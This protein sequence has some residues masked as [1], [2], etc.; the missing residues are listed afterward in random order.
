[1][2]LNSNK[3]H[4]NF[5]YPNISIKLFL[6]KSTLKQKGRA[7]KLQWGRRNWHGQ[8]LEQEE[9]V[10]GLSSSNSFLSKIPPCCAPLQQTPSGRQK[11]A[12]LNYCVKTT[13]KENK[14][15]SERPIRTLRVHSSGMKRCAKT[16]PSPIKSSP[17]TLLGF[18]MPIP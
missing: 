7:Q 17:V 4:N 2:D 3:T 10:L 6:S 11:D 1:M 8:Y 13:L 12:G 15:H 5:H 9:T 14:K 18:G 16:T